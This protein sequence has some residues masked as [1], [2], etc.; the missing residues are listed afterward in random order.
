MNDSNDQLPLP[1]WLVRPWAQKAARGAYRGMKSGGH[2]PFRNAGRQKIEPPLPVWRWK[3]APGLGFGVP[4]GWTDL[5]DQELLDRALQ[6]AQRTRPL[7]G[8]RA[9]ESD[10]PYTCIFV[11]PS[12]VPVTMSRDQFVRESRSW[13]LEF[14]ASN[15]MQ[16][17]SGPNAIQIGREPGTLLEAEQ[18][19][20]GEEYGIDHAVLASI[21]KI[22]AWRRKSVFHIAML[23]RADQHEAYVPALYTMLGTWRWW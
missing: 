9:E 10:N 22:F 1:R 15:A 12:P 17:V 3:Q 19:V 18:V 7:A 20:S 14:V 23:G 21:T 16:I 2:S 6:N 11:E 4:F 13:G 8:L 5:T